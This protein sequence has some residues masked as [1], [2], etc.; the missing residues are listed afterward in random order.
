[1]VDPLSTEE[2]AG[3]IMRLV[4]DAPLRG[5]LIAKGFVRASELTW[6]RTAASTLLV[7]EQLAVP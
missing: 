4:E 3:A 1:M 5:Q 6:R 2:I 7:Y